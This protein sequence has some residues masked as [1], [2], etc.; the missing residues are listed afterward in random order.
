MATLCTGVALFPHPPIMLPEIGGS[1]LNKIKK[2]VTAVTTASRMLTD[3]KPE[4]IVIISP[5][6]YVFPD[7]AAIFPEPKLYGNLGNCGYPELTMQ[8]NTDMELAGEIMAQAA[9]IVPLHALDQAWG[10]KYGHPVQIDQGSFIPLYYLRQAG[11][12]GAIVMMAPRFDDYNSMT[13]L[14]DITIRAALKINRRIAVIASGDLS[15]RLLP[16]SPNGYTPTG[17][18]FDKTVM[19]ALKKQDLHLLQTMPASLIEDAGMCGLPSIY[20]LFGVL[21]HLRPVMPVY[22]YEGPFGVGYG[23][24]LYLNEGEKRLAENSVT[25]D[26]RVRLARQSISYYL[27]HHT[28]MPLPDSLPAELA[29][30]AGAFVSI[31]QGTNLRGCIGTFLPMHLTIAGEII[32]NAVSAATRDPRFQPVRLGEL[33]DLSISVDILG[34]PESVTSADQLDPEKYGV[35]VMSHARTGLLLPA[36]DGVDTVQQQLDIAKEKAGIPPQVRPDIYRFTVTRY[37]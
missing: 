22:S 35:I 11:F 29:G 7:G 25:T 13:V 30:Q 37:L 16:N 24:A 36:L 33:D 28:Y 19:T 6:N 12:T 14:G 31:H 18:V 15:H 1:E 21:R 23:V 3:Q 20:F 27:H 4:T 17:E 2:T 10:I 32:H 8:V 34:A 5:H 26:I 9:N